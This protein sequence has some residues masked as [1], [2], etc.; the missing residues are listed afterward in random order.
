MRKCIRCTQWKDESE[1]NIRDQK[2]GYLQ[3]VCKTCQQEQGRERY[4]NDPKN[5]KEINRASRWRAREDARRFIY[6]YLTGR[7]CADCGESDI[8]VL[9]FDHVRGEKKMNIADMVS[10]GS[11][12][13]AI[14]QELEKTDIVCFNCHMKR[15]WRKRGYERFER[16]R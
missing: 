10:Q 4:S 12:L 15:E 1:F 3:S 14:S 16:A 9:T 7:T 2:R 11:S 6:E 5:V 13:K 8:T